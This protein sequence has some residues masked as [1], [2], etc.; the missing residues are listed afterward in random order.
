MAEK[1]S[2]QAV[3][4]RLA[5]AGFARSTKARGRIRGLSEH[6]EGFAVS[7]WGDGDVRV[8]HRMNSFVRRDDSA[9]ILAM[10]AKYGEALTEGGL[11]WQQ[12]SEAGMTPALI[13]TKE[14]A[15]G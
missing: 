7:T 6:T 1:L 8:V 5:K 3:S 4:A 15:H 10:L 9:R 2:P 11:S 12:T 14:K 13:V